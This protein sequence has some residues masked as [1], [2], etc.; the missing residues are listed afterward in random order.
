M[1]LERIRRS[2]ESR[3]NNIA[4]NAAMPYLKT[5]MLKWYT[6]L[7][8]CLALISQRAIT[9]STIYILSYS[10]G[11]LIFRWKYNHDKRAIN[12]YR[13]FLKLQKNIVLIEANND[14]AHLNLS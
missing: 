5:G 10:C 2:L 13:N 1:S 3:N 6:Y 8:I 7:G 14:N 4:L 9:S 11:D 12:K